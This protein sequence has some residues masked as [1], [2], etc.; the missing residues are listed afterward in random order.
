MYASEAKTI[1]DYRNLTNTEQ[2]IQWIEVEIKLAAKDGFYGF[3][4]DVP[5]EFR[6][7]NRKEIIDYYKKLGYDISLSSLGTYDYNIQW[8]E[9][10]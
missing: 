9:V 2:L 1:A 3:M 4:V 6:H 5:N 7:H 8:K 10:K